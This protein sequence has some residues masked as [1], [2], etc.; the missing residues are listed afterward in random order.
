MQLLKD[1]FTLWNVDLKAEQDRNL[2]EKIGAEGQGVLGPSGLSEMGPG[3][4]PSHTA[5]VKEEEEENAF[6]MK[7][8]LEA[9]IKER[10]KKKRFNTKGINEEQ[11]IIR[12]QQM[13]N[14]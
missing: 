9:R 10:S 13:E 11:Q 4:G 7:T 3:G 12:M 8:L 6:A 14:E 1:N 2:H 5:I